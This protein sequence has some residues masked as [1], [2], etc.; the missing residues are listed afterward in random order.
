MIRS[1]RRGSLIVSLPRNEVTLAQAARDAGADFLKVHINVHHRASGTAFGS[2]AQ[3]R[4]R[5]L[6]VLAVGLPTG[7]V[8]GEETMISRD[9]LPQLRAM[10][11]AYLDAFIHVLPAYLYEIG[12]PIIPA[13]PHSIDTRYLQQIRALPGTWVEAAIVDAAGYGQPPAPEDFKALRVAAEGTGKQLIVPTQRRILPTDLPRYFEI[14]GVAALAI[15]AIV[16]G[17]DPVA[18]AHATRAFRHALDQCVQ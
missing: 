4:E 5:L 7:L 14:P 3:E 13:L 10:G 16:T 2:L 11:F 18:L 17:A 1:L 8:P 9:E 15:G 6:Q 12:V